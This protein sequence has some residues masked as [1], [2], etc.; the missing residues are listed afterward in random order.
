MYKIFVIVVIPRLSNIKS[1]VA[2]LDLN[3]ICNL[4]L[5]ISVKIE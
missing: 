2:F 1:N 4:K 5:G 3:L